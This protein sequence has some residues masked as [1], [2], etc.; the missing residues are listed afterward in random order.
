MNLLK[1][2]WSA[3]EQ[4]R[5]HDARVNL[6]NKDP[7][8]FFYWT[9]PSDGSTI[10]WSGVWLFKSPTLA[11]R[12]VEVSIFWE[13][14]DNRSGECSPTSSCMSHL[15]YRAY[16]SVK[17]SLLIIVT[18]KFWNQRME[19]DIWV[20]RPSTKIVEAV[21]DEAGPH[22][23]MTCGSTWYNTTAKRRI[24]RRLHRAADVTMRVWFQF[25]F[26]NWI[27]RVHLVIGYKVKTGTER[28]RSIS[29]ITV[30]DRVP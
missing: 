27:W 12:W 4:G 17:R 15:P 22:W 23:G 2:Q 24:G 29:R 11:W 25:G 16:S 18:W 14:H 6:T 30:I 3:V 21:V 7:F 20:T 1:R 8:H 9:V 19:V 13:D 5:W 26:E 10:F 28:I